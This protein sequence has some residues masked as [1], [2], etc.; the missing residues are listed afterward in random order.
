MII[1]NFGMKMEHPFD[2]DDIKINF[3]ITYSFFLNKL[4]N[5]I[6]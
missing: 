1:V 3:E 6:Y 4:K 2:V 5:R